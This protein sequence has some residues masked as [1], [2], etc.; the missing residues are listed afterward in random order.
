MNVKTLGPVDPNCSFFAK[1]QCLRPFEEKDVC[2][3]C[4]QK[5][6]DDLQAEVRALKKKG[7]Q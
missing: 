4:L 2:W 7:A 6:I 1:G 3:A 5:V